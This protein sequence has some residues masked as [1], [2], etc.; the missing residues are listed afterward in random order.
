MVAQPVLLWLSAVVLGVHSVPS[1]L[2]EDCTEQQLNKA[3]LR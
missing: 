1:T 3:K 2:G